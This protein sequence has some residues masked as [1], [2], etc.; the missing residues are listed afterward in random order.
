MITLQIQAVEGV[1]A[2]GHIKDIVHS[3]KEE[4]E[5]KSVP[6]L[7]TSRLDD[8][9]RANVIHGVQQLQTQS[10]IIKEKVAKKELQIIGAR[11]DLHDFK[12]TILR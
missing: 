7:D 2:L 12:V 10:L 6:F 1:E 8:C 9:V 11:Y 5:I 3:L 4:A